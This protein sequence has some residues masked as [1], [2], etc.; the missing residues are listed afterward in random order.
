[1]ENKVQ[2][3]D[4]SN[5]NI[6]TYKKTDALYQSKDKS[7][8][9]AKLERALLLGNGNKQH[10]KIVFKNAEGLIF[11]TEATIWG[12]TENYVILKGARM[13]PIKSIIEII[14]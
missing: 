4:K 12:L 11:D 6:L 13:I 8:R 1:M 5:I 10:V 7:I 9:Q 3:I 2:T 14:F